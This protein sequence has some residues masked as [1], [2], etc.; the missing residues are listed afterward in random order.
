M[1]ILVSIQDLQERWEALL[2]L[3]VISGMYFVRSLFKRKD[4]PFFP[5]SGI[6]EKGYMKFLSGLIL[7]AIIIMVLLVGIK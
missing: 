3:L 5:G 1:D 6:T 7:A 4:E 2:I